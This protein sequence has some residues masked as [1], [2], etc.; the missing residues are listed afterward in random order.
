MWSFQKK[1]TPP[2][3]LTTVKV[4][5]NLFFIGA[6]DNA[7]KHNRGSLQIIYANAAAI[8]LNCIPKQFP[9]F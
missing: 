2:P 1:S 7:S 8:I 4:M 5:K 6:I 3:P 9:Y